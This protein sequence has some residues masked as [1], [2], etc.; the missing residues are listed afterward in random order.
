[1]D[2]FRKIQTPGKVS[3]IICNDDLKYGAEGLRALT[4]HVQ[5]N[6]HKVNLA[7]VLFSNKLKYVERDTTYGLP[8]HLVEKD[9]HREETTE[10]SLPITF[11]DR[12]SM[13]EAKVLGVMAEHGLPLGTA[14]SM[15]ELA[16]DLAKDPKVLCDLE[17]GRSSI[18]YKLKFGVA[19]TFHSRT[20]ENLKKTHFSLNMDESF[21]SNDQKVLTILVSYFSNSDN[22]IVVEHLESI[23]LDIVNSETVY[24]ELVNVFEKYKIPWNNL[25]SILMDS[26]GVMRGSKKGVETRVRNTVAPH[27]LDIDGDVCH[28]LHNV[29]KR[30]CKPFE[31]HVEIFFTDLYTHFK[32][33][34]DLRRYLERICYILG[35]NFTKPDRFLKHRWLSVYDVSV[36]VLR[37]FDL[38]F[39]FFYSCLS[40]EDQLLY[41]D[42]LKN[43]YEKHDL[44][45]EDKTE[46]QTIQRKIK[47]KK[48]GTEQGEA[49]KKRIIKCLTDDGK[50]T[51]LII[52]FYTYALED[53]KTY[54]CLFQSKIPLVHLLNDKQKDCYVKFLGYFFKASEIKDMK[55]KRLKTFPMDDEKYHLKEK[56]IGWGA[57]TIKIMEEI[58]KNH[59]TLLWFKKAVKK[60]YLEGAKQMQKTV[61]IDNPILQSFSAIDPVLQ[62]RAPDEMLNVLKKLPDRMKN[63]MPQEE[64]HIWEDDYDKEIRSFMKDKSLP[65]YKP[66]SDDENADENDSEAVPSTQAS[67]LITYSRADQWWGAVKK[68]GKYKILTKIVLAAF[69]CFH[70]PLV[71]S[72][73]NN[74][75]NIMD[76]KRSS[77]IIGT[78]NAYLTMQYY[79]KTHN[80]SALKLLSRK[81]P[82]HDAIDSEL[83]YNIKNAWKLN[84]EDQKERADKKRPDL[85][86]KIEHRKKLIKE[87]KDEQE[88]KEKSI[89]R[90]RNL[91]ILDM[92]MK[93]KTKKDEK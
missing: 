75:G 56:D 19:K 37:C 50:K 43:L 49:R 29:A 46:I 22:Q 61:P 87:R 60:A 15:I 4:N 85:K 14:K 77:M 66:P 80:T 51:K 76:S 28:H 89:K 84:I 44:T 3:C 78:Y 11:A 18:T 55:P 10:F 45:E 81:D 31:D 6:K 12:K 8:S 47:S 57:K 53:L 39:I 33:S 2:D 32:Y 65:E 91:S 86:T 30:F 48:M 72:S 54:V 73:F 27:L 42:V 38:Y 64:K 13:A 7:A 40:K 23:S 9:I 24:K 69:S 67:N 36:S 68:T 52:T 82:V 93:K 74:M 17:M 5:L 70:G 59:P 62:K 1:M 35:L 20:I 90:K 34:P 25:C 88:A 83:C 63:I 41:R 92:L 79:F 26:C 58:G 21:S 16:Q 71:E